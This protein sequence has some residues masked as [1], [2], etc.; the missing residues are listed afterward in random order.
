[1]ISLYTLSNQFNSSLFNETQLLKF[2]V[3]NFWQS[4]D[5][6]S[7]W[8]YE[9][10]PWNLL[11]ISDR[12]KMVW[13]NACETVVSWIRKNWWVVSFMIENHN[14]SRSNVILHSQDTHFTRAAILNSRTRWHLSAWSENSTF[15]FSLRYIRSH[16]LINKVCLFKAEGRLLINE[17]TYRLKP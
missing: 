6:G 2:V 4:I 3:Y 13:P 17:L 9:E 10:R 1:M 15:E 11:F 7:T 5:P 16:F 14:R 12:S 8:A